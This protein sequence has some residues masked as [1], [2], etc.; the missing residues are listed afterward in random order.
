MK[1]KNKKGRIV[2]HWK[3]YGNK[4]KKDK[5]R[6]ETKPCITNKFKGHTHKVRKKE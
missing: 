5:S 1:Y 4:K 3:A 2:E 6:Y